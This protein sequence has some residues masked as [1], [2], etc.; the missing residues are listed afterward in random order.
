[1][2]LHRDHDASFREH[3]HIHTEEVD[4][5][6]FLGRSTEVN[7]QIRNSTRWW[8]PQQFMERKDVVQQVLDACRQSGF[9]AVVRNS[10]SVPYG[11]R[12]ATKMICARGTVS[13]RTATTAPNPAGVDVPHP[14]FSVD[15]HR[16]AAEMVPQTSAPSVPTTTTVQAQ[17]IP[18]RRGRKYV[19]KTDRMY[20]SNTTKPMSDTD[21]CPFSITIYQSTIAPHVA[22]WFILQFGLGSNVIVLTVVWKRNILCRAVHAYQKMR[23]SW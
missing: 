3:I 8:F 5:S 7:P 13:S 10:S 21:I 18:N 19:R 16:N 9:R 17:V 23:L 2:G 1:L 22:R 6:T 11:N 20:R 14:P 4:V 15:G 12:T